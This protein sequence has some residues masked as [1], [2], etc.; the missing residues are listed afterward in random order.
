MKTAT[1]EEAVTQVLESAL[2]LL[3]KLRGYEQ[4]SHLGPEILAL[5]D[6]AGT[7]APE[8]MNRVRSRIHNAVSRTVTGET[9]AYEVYLI[10]DNT[11]LGTYTP[12]DGHEDTARHI[13]CEKLSSGQYSLYLRC[14]IS[15][16]RAVD[17]ADLPQVCTR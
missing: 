9:P 1:K 16:L 3:N 2:M 11:F 4:P 14:K 8:M 10:S 7:V 6:Q 5:Y 17:V 13:A 15:D 12:F